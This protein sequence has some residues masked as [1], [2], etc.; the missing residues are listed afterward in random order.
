MDWSRLYFGLYSAVYA[1]GERAGGASGTRTVVLAVLA[2]DLF[3]AHVIGDGQNLPAL[4]IWAD[5]L[6]GHSDTYR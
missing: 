2:L 6:N 1:G 5:D 3:A 4:Q